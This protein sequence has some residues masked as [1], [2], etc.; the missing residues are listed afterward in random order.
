MEPQ[1]QYCAD[2]LRREDYKHYIACLYLD[3]E[4]RQAGFAIFAFNRKIC[5]IP[6]LV[7]EP[8]P[9]EIRIGWWRDEIANTNIVSGDPVARALQEVITRYALPVKILDRLLDARI[10][11]LYHDTVADK[12]ELETYL[13]DTRSSLFHLLMMISAR[14]K[15][16]SDNSSD[17]NDADIACDHAGI[18]TGIVELLVDLP[19]YEHQNQTFFP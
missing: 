18:F 15:E 19:R 14:N 1:F 7:S 17:T 13:T 2:I 4:L 6:M 8:M 16:N 10:F 11:D 5:Q 3:D 12:A 9:G